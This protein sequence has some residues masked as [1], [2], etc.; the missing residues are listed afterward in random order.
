MNIYLHVSKSL[1][2]TNDIIFRNMHNHFS[3]AAKIIAIDLLYIRNFI[4]SN[5][6]DNIDFLFNNSD[7]HFRNKIYLCLQ[8]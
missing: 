2:I 3:I 5:E 8:L 1:K 6:S 4:H 7:F